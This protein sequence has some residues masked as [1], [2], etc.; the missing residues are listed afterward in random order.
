MLPSRPM[1]VFSKTPK[2]PAGG[3]G[4]RNS[5]GG[6]MLPFAPAAAAAVPS[7]SDAATK[8]RVLLMTARAC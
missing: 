1:G 8:V 5:S 4:V 2:R 3:G 6:A 7:D